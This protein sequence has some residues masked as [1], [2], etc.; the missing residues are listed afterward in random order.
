MD[1]S[2]T[3]STGKVP[4]MHEPLL[5]QAA[6]E[7]TIDVLTGRRVAVLERWPLKIHWQDEKGIWR[8]RVIGTNVRIAAK[9]ANL[10]KHNAN[11]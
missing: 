11:S 2:P 7:T 1:S 8:E 6:Q 5:A 4:E 3:E 9:A 10:E